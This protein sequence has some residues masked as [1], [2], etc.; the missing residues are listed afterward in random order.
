MITISNKIKVAFSFLFIHFSVNLFL[1]SW[2]LK[3]A[4]FPPRYLP[5]VPL[6]NA[7][8]SAFSGFFNGA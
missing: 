4:I 8:P 2:G 7:V 1:P 6:Q 5:K 3:H